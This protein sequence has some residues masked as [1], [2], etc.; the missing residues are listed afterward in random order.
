M[1]DQTER[2]PVL[3]TDINGETH[4]SPPGTMRSFSLNEHC[5]HAGVH[6]ETRNQEFYEAVREPRER[7][8]IPNGALPGECEHGRSGGPFE[9]QHWAWGPTVI[10]ETRRK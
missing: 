9:P 4:D 8:W 1:S 7:P 10:V 6:A 5:R 2:E 3:W